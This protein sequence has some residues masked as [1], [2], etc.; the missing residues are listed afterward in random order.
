MVIWITFTFLYT[1]SSLAILFW[2]LTSTRHYSGKSQKIMNFSE[3]L[4]PVCHQ[5][6]CHLKSNWNHLSCLLWCLVCTLAD[7]LDQVCMSK[8]TELLSCDWPKRC[9]EV[10]VNEQLNRSSVITSIMT[11][12]IDGVMGKMF[13]HLS[14][15][16]IIILGLEMLQQ[17]VYV[18]SWVLSFVFQTFE[19]TAIFVAWNRG[20]IWEA[21]TAVIWNVQCLPACITL[22]SPL[23]ALHL[24]LWACT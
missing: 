22:F 10:Y 19:C 15:H 13:T 11:C 14:H 18:R 8:W 17:V 12:A 3:I 4:S 16:T 5:Q 9:L 24:M 6:P 21:C 1:R 20:E 2:S 7:H 23:S